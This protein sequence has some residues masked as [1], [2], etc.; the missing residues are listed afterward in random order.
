MKKMARFNLDAS[1]LLN[2]DCDDIVN[3]LNNIESL[4]DNQEDDTL[5]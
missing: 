1:Q 2:V 5:Q 3:A 4:L